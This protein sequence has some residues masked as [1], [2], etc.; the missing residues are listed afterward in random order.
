VPAPDRVGAYQQ[1]QTPQCRP[2]QPMYSAANN[3]RSAGANR[4]F[5][6]TAAN[7]QDRDAARTLV[8]YAAL[9]GI[10]HVWADSGYH[11]EVIAWAVTTLAVT[12]EIVEP[13]PGVKGLQVLPRRWVVERTLAWI[14]RRR[15][16]ARDYERLID[17]HET[18]VHWAAIIH[19]TRRRARLS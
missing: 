1:P 11:G 2:R 14:T 10:G 6:V 18:T 4:T 17:H 19:M 12:I 13:Q 16:C 9:H 8:E 5:Y 7:T 3:A 15:R